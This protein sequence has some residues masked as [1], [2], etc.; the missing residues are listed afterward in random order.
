MSLANEDIRALMDKAV[1]S[2]KG[3]RL[4]LPDRGQCV[5]VMWQCY[6]VRRADRKLMCEIYQPEEPQFNKSEY[7]ILVFRYWELDGQWWLEM[8]KADP[9]RFDGMIEFI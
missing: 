7:D 5:R 8:A 3:L 4:L 2:E 1:E 6:N 9:G